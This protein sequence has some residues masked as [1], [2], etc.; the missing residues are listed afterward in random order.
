MPPVLNTSMI[1]VPAVGAE[2]AGVDTAVPGSATHISAS[3]APGSA[4]EAV[5]VENGH[6][7]LTVFFAIGMVINVLLVT[8]YLV[9]AVRQ[10]RKK[11]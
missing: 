6:E 9:W 5:E 10:W 7:D 3:M 8:A 2:S 4:A 1:N 11:K